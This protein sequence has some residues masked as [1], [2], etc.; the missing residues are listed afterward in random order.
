MPRPEDK[1]MKLV[2]KV[3]K[4]VGLEFQS[5]DINGSEDYGIKG[6]LKKEAYAKKKG[7]SEYPENTGVMFY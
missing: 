3:L 5:H 1:T 2:K 6:N 7:I 4:N